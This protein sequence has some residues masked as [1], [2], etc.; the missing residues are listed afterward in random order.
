MRAHAPAGSMSGPGIAREL[1]SGLVSRGTA[2][3]GGAARAAGLGATP[4]AEVG[5]GEGLAVFKL[6]KGGRWHR[7]FAILTWVATG[8]G[9]A[10]AFLTF[11]ELDMFGREHVFTGAIRWSKQARDRVLGITEEQKREAYRRAAEFRALEAAETASSVSAGQV[12]SR[13]AR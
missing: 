11:E 12:E 6:A 5:S 7:P 2:G 13:A 10:S 3:S 9:T 8:L 4:G 1:R